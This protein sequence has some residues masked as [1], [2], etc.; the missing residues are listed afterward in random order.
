M[1]DE[2][3]LAR[4]V[5]NP[6]ERAPGVSEEERSPPKEKLPKL[7]KKQVQPMHPK[8][9]EI[10]RAIYQKHAHAFFDEMKES[11][12]K[13]SGQLRRQA[14]KMISKSAA[15]VCTSPHQVEESPVP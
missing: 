5:P 8:E 12:A 13:E 2:V 1:K 14:L 7:L 3:V 11:F 15:Q 10:V 6:D 4:L 9:E